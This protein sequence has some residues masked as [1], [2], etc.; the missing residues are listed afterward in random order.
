MS[1]KFVFLVL[2]QL[3][4]LDLAGP[5]QVLHEANYFGADFTIEYCSLQSDNYTTNGLVFGKLKQFNEVEISANDFL[6]IPGP[7]YKYLLTE[8]FKNNSN[9][10]EWIRK[11]HQ[12]GVKIVSV[13]SGAF[14]LAE[15]GILNNQNCTTHFKLTQL[16]KDLYPRINVLEN[17]LFTQS[18]SLYTSAGISSGIDLMLHIVEEIKGS[19]FAYQVAKEMVVYNR[20][21]GNHSQENSLLSHRNHIHTGIHKVQDWIIENIN[22]KSNLFEL[23]EL[24]NMSER[25]FTR[26]FKKETSITVNNYITLIRKEKIKEYLK[27]PDFSRAEIASSVGLQSER[28][29]SRIINLI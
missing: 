6:I 24:A 19:H 17:I 2:P 1:T 3:Q 21:S 22:K 14:V 4:L 27:N 9:L 10:F 12:K 13:C 23:A 29:L 25:N 16:L 28:Q 18:N 15:S 26:I 11:N 20:R 8:D 7:N 5:D